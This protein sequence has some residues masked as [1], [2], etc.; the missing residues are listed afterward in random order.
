MTVGLLAFFSFFGNRGYCCSG[1]A[2]LNSAVDE[3]PPVLHSL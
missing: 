1:L 2:G 3:L